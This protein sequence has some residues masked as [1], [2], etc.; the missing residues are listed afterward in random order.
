MKW[1]PRIIVNGE[2]LAVICS[3]NEYNLGKL[4]CR[5]GVPFNRLRSHAWQAGWTYQDI[6]TVVESEIGQRALDKARKALAQ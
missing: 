4:D 6:H 3:M 1:Q 2:S 5:N